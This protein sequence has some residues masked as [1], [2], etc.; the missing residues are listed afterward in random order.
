MYSDSVL[1]ITSAS[2]VDGYICAVS[3]LLRVPDI[4]ASDFCVI[5][6]PCGFGETSCRLA[7]AL[8]I[9]L[10]RLERLDVLAALPPAQRE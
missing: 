7:V 6:L 3:V 10:A 8:Y 2:A 4:L 1:N 9:M 5:G